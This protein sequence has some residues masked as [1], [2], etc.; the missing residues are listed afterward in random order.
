MMGICT[1]RWRRWELNDLELNLRLGEWIPDI[2]YSTL[3]LF[4]M[5]TAYGG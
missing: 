1:G 2:G 4:L 5:G 3:S